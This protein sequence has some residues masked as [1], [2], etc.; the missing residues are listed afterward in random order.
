MLCHCCVFFLLPVCTLT[1]V[2]V[3]D[4]RKEFEGLEVCSK[5]VDQIQNFSKLTSKWS[6]YDA[7]EQV[8]MRSVSLCSYVYVKL[9][10]FS[11]NSVSKWTALFKEASGLIFFG[12]ESFLAH[13]PP[14][15]LVPLSL[16]GT[17]VHTTS[18]CNNVYLIDCS[19]A[20]IMDRV[21]TSPSMLHQSKLDSHK[22]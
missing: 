8:L 4:P 3:L 6:G 19:V 20:V 9:Y 21:H 5:V 13:L 10:F 16:R 17:Y 2:D 12:P 15:N 1:L 14:T 7:G 18:G 11:F 22:R